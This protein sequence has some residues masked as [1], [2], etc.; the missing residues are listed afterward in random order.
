M[1]TRLTFFAL[2]LISLTFACANALQLAK[3]TGAQ[4]LQCPEDQVTVT[5]LGGDQYRADGCG[6][7]ELLSCHA[8]TKGTTYSHGCDN[9]DAGAKK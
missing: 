7:S 9:P 1:K 3:S 5:S 4:R 8:G 6:K 2:G